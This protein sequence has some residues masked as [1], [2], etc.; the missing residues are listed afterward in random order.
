MGKLTKPRRVKSLADRFWA[1]VD[2]RGPDECWL[3]TGCRKK[4][5]GYGKIGEGRMGQ[6]TLLAHRVSW[7]ITNG[8]IPDGAMVLHRCDNPPCVNPRHLF[9]GDQLDNM[10]DMVSKGRQRYQGRA[11]CSHGHEFTPENTIVRD[12]KYRRCRTCYDLTMAAYR[13]R[14]KEAA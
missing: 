14:A 7:E 2:K 12:G 13:Q 3:W 6:R 8:S 1:K 4:A 5:F 9:L 11:H 10:R